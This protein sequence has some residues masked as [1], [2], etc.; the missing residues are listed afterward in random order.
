[1]NE[2]AT[3]LAIDDNSESLALLVR[4][5]TSEGYHVRPADS[6]EL[7]LAAIAAN[8][9]DLILL[10]V[11]LKGMDGLEVCQRLKA[12]EATRRIPIILI[13]AFAEVQ[14]WVEG[15]KMGASDY[16]TKPFQIEE[17][18]SRVKTHLALGQAKI[19]LEQQATALR[20]TNEELQTEVVNRQRVETEMRQSIE[21]AGLS[22]RAMLSALDDQKRTEEKINAFSVELERSNK[23]LEQFAYI[24]SHDL[25]EPL[26]MV[27]SYLTL[28]TERYGGKLDAD[29]R[30]F[31]GYALEGGARMSRLINALLAYSRLG[32]RGKAFEDV[33]CETILSQALDN[34]QV[35][36][37]ES[38]AVVTHDP[39]P[40]VQ[41]DDTQ[42]L[43]LFQNLL[44]NAIK[45]RS[46]EP[47]RVHISAK[48]E[49][50]SFVFSVSDNGIGID[51]QYYERIFIIFQRLHN[52]EDYPGTGIGLAISKRIVERHGGRIWIESLPGKGSTFFFTLPIKGESQ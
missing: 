13:S 51:P 17:L 21:Q 26:R 14:D 40:T 16:I 27:N 7:A 12:G 30:E 6:G 4:I 34:L 45:F 2:Q 42:L 8:L 24:V 43:Q 52:R 41:G 31:I 29:A 32:T 11:R 25:Q 44:G 1:M 37:A 18:L 22:H 10:D 49:G 9:P 39:L 19:S 15:L 36:I 48:A 28:L 20:Q 23:E 38:Q 35:A 3:I 50:G 47:P 46:A 33:N 5:L